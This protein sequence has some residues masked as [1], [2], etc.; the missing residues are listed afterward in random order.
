MRIMT[1]DRSQ[2]VLSGSGFTVIELLIAVLITGILAAASFQFYITMQQ[3]VTTQQD[4]SDMQQMNRACLQEIGK[5][6]RLAGYMLPPLH[7]AYEIAGDHI[8]VYTG[9]DSA[10]C[11]WPVDTTEYYLE[12]YTETEYATVPFRPDGMVLYKLMKKEDDWPEPLPFADFI[13]SIRYDITRPDS[14]E[15]AVTLE[16]QTCKGDESFTGNDGFRTFINTERVSI[17][18]LSIIEEE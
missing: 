15:L 9:C 18:N 11:A 17:R 5:T 7:P 2:R 6:L 4:I 1:S 14:T 8:S 12:E 16:V 13:T 10:S 3:Q